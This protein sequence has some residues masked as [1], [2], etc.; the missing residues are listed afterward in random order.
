MGGVGGLAFTGVLDG[1]EVGIVVEGFGEME[2]GV[3]LVVVGGTCGGE[4]NVDFS[5]AA[6]DSILFSMLFSKVAPKRCSKACRSK[7]CK[8]R[9][10][11]LVE[12]GCTPCVGG[13]VVLDVTN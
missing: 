12:G 1:A 7:A 2:V 13:V 3:V 6:I 5:E 11:G 10:E 4:A 8:S 9:F